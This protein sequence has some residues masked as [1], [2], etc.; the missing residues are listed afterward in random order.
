MEELYQQ[1]QRRI[2]PFKDKFPQL[3]SKLEW[4]ETLEGW[5]LLIEKLSQIIQDH[6]QEI[7]E[8]LRDQI[9][10]TQIKQKFGFLR[11]YLNHS[12]PYIRGAVMMAVYASTTVCEKC[13]NAATIHNINNWFTTLCEEHYQQAIQEKK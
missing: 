6:L 1:S 10:F 3:F 4:F 8:E 9:Y 13:G 7:P 2:A 5:D 12:T 11:A